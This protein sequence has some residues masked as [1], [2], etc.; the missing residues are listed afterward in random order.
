MTRMRRRGGRLPSESAPG[1]P[2][3]T[4]IVSSGLDLLVESV[5]VLIPERGVPHQQDVEN[6]ACRDEREQH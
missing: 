1:S 6:D 5:L 4:Y 3:P 2:G